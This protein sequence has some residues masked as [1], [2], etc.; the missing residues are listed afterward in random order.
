MENKVSVHYIGVSPSVIETLTSHDEIE[1][2]NHRNLQSA[3]NYLKTGQKPDAILCDRYLSSG[4]DG[5][6]YYD[7]LRKKS[8]F[9]PSINYFICK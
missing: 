3:E 5:I 7:I 1:M 8:E 9:T 4:G 2:I 6:E